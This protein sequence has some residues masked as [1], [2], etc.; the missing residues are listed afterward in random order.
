MLLNWMMNKLFWIMH[1]KQF[2]CNVSSTDTKMTDEVYPTEMLH[3]W[4]W[5]PINSVWIIF[6]I[7]D[8]LSF[9]FPII[10][11]Q[12]SHVILSC[13]DVK[14]KIIHTVSYHCRDKIKCTIKMQLKS[15][16]MKIISTHSELFYVL[17]LLCVSKR[18][19]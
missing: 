3:L 10:I 15:S 17:M 13:S 4:S 2:K 16:V 18:S 14:C 7:K 5:E 12:L 19:L 11:T 1:I 8:N 6:L 9:L